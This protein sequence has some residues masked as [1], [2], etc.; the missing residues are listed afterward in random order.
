[1][2]Y[3]ENTYGVDYDLVEIVV[4]NDSPIVGNCLDDIETVY[5]IRVIAN[6]RSGEES[7]MGSC[8]LARDMTIEPGMVLNI[9]R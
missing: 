3:F 1:M 7:R 8:I 9:P 2:D 6:K 4:P 5:R